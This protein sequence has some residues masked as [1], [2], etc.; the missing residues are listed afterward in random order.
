MVKTP[1]FQCRGLGSVPGRGTEN[2]RAV[3]HGVKKKK[4]VELISGQD[5]VSTNLKGI[6]F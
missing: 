1:C 4:L 3:Q 6:Q 5:C 2:P